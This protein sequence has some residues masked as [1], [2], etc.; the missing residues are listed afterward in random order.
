MLL[1][2]GVVAGLLTFNTRKQSTSPTLA[3]RLFPLA[4][5]WYW[6]Q[7]RLSLFPASLALAVFGR[8]RSLGWQKK[9]GGVGASLGFRLGKLCPLCGHNVAWGRNFAVFCPV[10][11][12]LTLSLVLLVF[13]AKPRHK[14][15]A[16]AVASFVSG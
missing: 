16:V 15:C 10:G 8:K 7:L 12:H 3:G 6:I 4:S 11:Q 5:A 9:V 1:W 13:R 14:V 2:C